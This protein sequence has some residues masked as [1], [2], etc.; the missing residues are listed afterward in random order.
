M[1]DITYSKTGVLFP[2]EPGRI[3]LFA[4]VTRPALGLTQPPTEW[5]PQEFSQAVKWPECEAGHL[6]PRL[7][8]R[9]A[10]APLTNT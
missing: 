6:V 8:V 1:Q 3:L 2:A 7:R 10:A 4:T 5:V 9:G